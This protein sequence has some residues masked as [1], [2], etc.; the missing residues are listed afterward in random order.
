MGSQLFLRKDVNKT[1]KGGKIICGLKIKKLCEY[2]CD[3]TRDY[4]LNQ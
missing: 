2:D 4:T 1:V 3:N